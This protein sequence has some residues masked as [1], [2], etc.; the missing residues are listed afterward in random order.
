MFFVVAIGY[1][2]SPF[3][4]ARSWNIQKNENVNVRKKAKQSEAQKKL[5][6]IEAKHEIAHHSAT[7]E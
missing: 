7:R 5:P 1:D 6:R 3:V 2:I 4:L